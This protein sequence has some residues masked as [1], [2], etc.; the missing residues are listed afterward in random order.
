MFLFCFIISFHYSVYFI[1]FFSQMANSH[2]KITSIKWNLNREQI[3]KHILIFIERCENL[4]EI[5]QAMIDF[6]RYLNFML[7]RIVKFKYLSLFKKIFPQFKKVYYNLKKVYFH[8]SIF[9]QD[10]KELN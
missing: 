2:D 7:R 5:C 4:I 3:F 8:L 10:L 6:G 9:L 1:E